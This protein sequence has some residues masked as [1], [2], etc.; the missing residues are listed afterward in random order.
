MSTSFDVRVLRVLRGGAVIG[1]HSK[2]IRPTNKEHAFWGVIGH[3]CAVE[4]RA[5]DQ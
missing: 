1:A 5:A 4:Q 3:S 2:I